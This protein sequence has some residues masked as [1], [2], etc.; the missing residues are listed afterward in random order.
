MTTK[1]SN[2]PCHGSNQQG[3]TASEARDTRF[4]GCSRSDSIHINENLGTD[5][6]EQTVMHELGHQ[7]G[8]G[9]H[10]V[11][12]GIMSRDMSTATSCITQSDLDLV[13]E[14]NECLWEKAECQ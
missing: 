10:A 11:G 12:N 1:I 13:C 14:V 9:H 2:E 7:L 4:V 6:T 8:A 3:A 5:E